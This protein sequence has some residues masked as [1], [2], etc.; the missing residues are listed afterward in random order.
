MARRPRP[1]RLEAYLFDL[2]GVLTQT[3]K[4]HVAAWKEMFDAYLRARA[5]ATG[6]PFEPF[7]LA[8]YTVHVDGRLRQDGVRTFLASRGTELPEGPP[9]GPP[10]PDTGRGLAPR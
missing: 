4:V 10:A 5:G 7:E 9:E 3:A 8:D 1:E 6:A 2:D